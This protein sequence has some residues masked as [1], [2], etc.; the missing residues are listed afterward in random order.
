MKRASLPAGPRP[1][2]PASSAGRVG[3]PWQPGAASRSRAAPDLHR[4]GA[5]GSAA[6]G[7]K[8]AL[9]ATRPSPGRG[10]PASVPSVKSGFVHRGGAGPSPPTATLWSRPCCGRRPRA[11]G[12]VGRLLQWPF[13]PP[14][15]GAGWAPPAAGPTSG[16]SLQGREL[17]P[18]ALGSALVLGSGGVGWVDGSRRVFA[19]FL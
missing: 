14:R 13:P 6:L 2:A 16:A 4:R 12:S 9:A 3:L 8:G 19:R 1:A 5:P 17:P 18:E 11:R 15:A 10:T 7:V